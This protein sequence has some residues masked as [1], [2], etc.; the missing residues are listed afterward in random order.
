MG[1]KLAAPD[2]PVFAAAGDGSAIFANPVA[3]Y[4]IAEAQNLSIVVI[5][6]AF[7]LVS[8]EPNGPPSAIR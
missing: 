8:G 6:M 1:A 7:F 4:Q 2:R 3:C 5:V